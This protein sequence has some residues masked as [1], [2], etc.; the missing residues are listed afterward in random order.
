MSELGGELNKIMGLLESFLFRYLTYFSM[1][2]AFEFTLG[3]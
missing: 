3:L 1:Y 2:G